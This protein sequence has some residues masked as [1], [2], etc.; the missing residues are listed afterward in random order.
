MKVSGK[1]VV[2]ATA[3][4]G[5][6]T[7]AGVLI[8]FRKIGWDRFQANTKLMEGKN[9][10]LAVARAMIVCADTSGAL[11][12]RAP[13]VPATLA[14]VGGKT[15]HAT[16]ENWD[17]P[18]WKCAKYTHIGDQNFRY[19]WEKKSDTLGTVRLEA[20]FD[21]N[22]VAEAVYEQDVVCG[23]YGGEFRCRPGDYRDLAKLR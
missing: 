5:V 21:G 20:D 11:P 2:I 18:T 23:V 8:A 15:F 16:A 6:L 22:G 3:L 13:P 10:V 4:V 17:D 1:K 19:A 12:P 7:I 14:E 9:N